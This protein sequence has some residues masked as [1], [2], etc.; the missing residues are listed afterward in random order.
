MACVMWGESGYH[1]SS[2]PVAIFFPG[3]ERAFRQRFDLFGDSELWLWYALNQLCHQLEPSRHFQLSSSHHPAANATG[4]IHAPMRST[5]NRPSS[6]GQARPL[7]CAMR[8]W[9]LKCSRGT[10]V[11]KLVLL[12]LVSKWDLLVMRWTCMTWNR[13]E[14]EVHGT[15][16]AF[17]LPPVFAFFHL[18][19][20][21]LAED[22]LGGFWWWQAS[23][24][25]AKYLAT[26]G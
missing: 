17:V 13:L 11:V 4:P 18:Q 21:L 26:A 5:G 12:V 20:Q 8:W 3:L 25:S 6:T 7:A 10:Q 16:G 24:T 23:Q 22:N 1:S 2:M 14:P 15:G 19:V 9:D